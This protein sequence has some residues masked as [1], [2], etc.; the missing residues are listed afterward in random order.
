MKDRETQYILEE[1]KEAIP[2][3]IQ[4]ELTNNSRRATPRSS[5]QMKGIEDVLNTTQTTMTS[6]LRSLDTNQTESNKRDGNMSYHDMARTL[7]LTENLLEK[8]GNDQNLEE[9]N[10]SSRRRKRMKAALE[11]IQDGVMDALGC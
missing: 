11:K 7:E 6:L 2:S 5:P 4:I 8:E 3:D 10:D 9:D 1:E